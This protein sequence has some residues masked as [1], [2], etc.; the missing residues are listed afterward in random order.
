M[1]RENGEVPARWLARFAT[2]TAEIADH[3]ERDDPFSRSIEYLI[4]VRP[5]GIA[6]LVLGAAQTSASTRSASRLIAKIKVA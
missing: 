1:A 3:L 6:D 2:F 4:R 5:D